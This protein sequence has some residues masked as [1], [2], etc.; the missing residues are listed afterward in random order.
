MRKIVLITT[1]Q[2]QLNI[3]ARF[4]TSL[5]N[6]I[7]LLKKEEIEAEYVFIEKTDIS[8]VHKSQIVEEFLKTEE[9][10]DFIFLK[11]NIIFKPQDIVDMLIKYEAQKIVGGSYKTDTHSQVPQLA[12]ELDLEKT[13]TMV[14][15]L[16]LI[17][18][19]SLADGFVKI[20]RKVFE[21]HKDIY[22]KFFFK[23]KSKDGDDFEE[24]KPFYFS[25]P[26]LGEDK[27]FKG[28]FYRFLNKVKT[29][30]EDLWCH[31]DFN[32][33]QIDGNYIHHYPL[34]DFIKMIEY[35]KEEQ[36]KQKPKEEEQELN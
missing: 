26:I 29:A 21:E 14:G 23:N 36:K 24:Q 31:L 13:E 28:S 7:D 5:I 34:R 22:D 30:G 3:D 8:D 20:N 19:S 16:N 17:K 11:S 9:V 10:S 12:I 25:A 15:D 32:A 6:T 18:V 27:Y 1:C 4:V 35:F 2:N 33:S